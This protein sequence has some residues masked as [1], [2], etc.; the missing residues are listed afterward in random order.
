[1]VQL[2]IILRSAY[3][4]TTKKRRFLFSRFMDS[5][6]I[7]VQGG[8]GGMGLPKYGGIGGP[9]GDVILEAHKG[10]TLRHV[11]KK[12]PHKRIRASTGTNSTARCIYAKKGDDHTIRVPAGITVIDD[13][14]RVLGEL[15]SVNQ[16][17]VVAKGGSGGCEET[18][19]SGVKG[20]HHCIRL[21]LKLLAD[22]ALVGF[23]N[24]GKSTFL[25]AITNAKPK[26]A[27]Y[28][29]TTIN[30]N[31]GIIE[32]PDL[33][34]ISIADLPGIVEGAHRNVGMGFQFLR[35]VER[36]KVMLW[37][38]DI[39]GFQL[40]K[41]YEYR[42]CL[43]TIVLLNKELEL[44]KD[45]L[46]YKPAI[47]LVNKMDL[48]GAQKKFDEIQDT[49]RHLS[50]FLEN[51]PEEFRPTQTVTFD[52]ILPISAKTSAKDIAEVKEIIRQYLDI[53]AESGFEDYEDYA[54]EMIKKKAKELGSK[55]A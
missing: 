28:P 6:R 3:I 54:F 23:P 47:L 13:Y 30:P 11:K 5:L 31:I 46:M 40:S 18:G 7:Y 38:V 21:D 34:T 27:K 8:P 32:Y 14:N 49:I 50:E 9:G 2:N 53:Q 43:E 45:Y 19:Y 41:Q 37:I 39:N 16:R 1:M 51:F 15:N 44:Y 52:H 26:I 36:T 29:F 20:Q 33:R 48:E 17:L 12:Y 22:V 25:K 10:I 24:A 42:T 35:H 55:W 4:D